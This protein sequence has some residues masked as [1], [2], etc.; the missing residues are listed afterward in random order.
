MIGTRIY[1]RRGAVGR[2]GGSAADRL[3]LRPQRL[4]LFEC[5]PVLGLQHRRQ[6][7]LIGHA[8]TNM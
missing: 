1:L 4:R 8:R 3:Q 7:R 6:P 2:D 5:L